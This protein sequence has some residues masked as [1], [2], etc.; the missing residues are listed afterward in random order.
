MNTQ[1]RHSHLI[2]REPKPVGDLPHH[3]S[4]KEKPMPGV[5]FM[6]GTQV[7]EAN[8]CVLCFFWKSIPPEVAGNIQKLPRAVPHKHDCDETYIMVGDVGGITFE[9]SLGEEQYEVDTPACV[10]LPKGIAHSIRVLRATAGATGGLI[11]VLF[12]PNYQT[13]PVD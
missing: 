12:Q 8:A 2:V 6:S 5:F 1:G 13:L 7:S 9:M 3:D 10:Y 11:P 4:D